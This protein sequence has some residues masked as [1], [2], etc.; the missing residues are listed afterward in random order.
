[1]PG[2]STS[3]HGSRY[4]NTQRCAHAPDATYERHPADQRRESSSDLANPSPCCSSMYGQ[5]KGRTMA[6]ERA[7]ANAA[8]AQKRQLRQSP[9]ETP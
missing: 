1:M 6:T 3:P 7:A 9:R 8:P 2:K 5:K 4:G